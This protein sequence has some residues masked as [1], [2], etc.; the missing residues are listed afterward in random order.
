M[1]IQEDKL[2]DAAEKIVLTAK[3]QLSGKA[4]T[5]K[6]QASKA[7]E[8]AQEAKSLRVFRNWLR[9]QMAREDFWQTHV[10]S[11]FLAE[12]IA[13]EVERIAG[14]AKSSEEALK[15]VI[16]FLGYFRRALVAID[17]LGRIPVVTERGE[18]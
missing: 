17:H 6:T 12:R 16:R 3:D 5:G 2:V 7:I 11:K 1:E 15:A 14:E 4:E 10:E 18:H 9:Y 13:E 8:V